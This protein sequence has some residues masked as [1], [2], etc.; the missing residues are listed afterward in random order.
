MFDCHFKRLSSARGSA[1]QLILNTSDYYYCTRVVIVGGKVQKQSVMLRLSPPRWCDVANFLRLVA[2]SAAT[3]RLQTTNH[4]STMS[5]H[6]HTTTTTHSICFYLDL[7]QS[8]VRQPSNGHIKHLTRSRT[9]EEDSRFVLAEWA[10]SAMSELWTVHRE[11]EMSVR[12]SRE[13]SSQWL[14]Q[15][16]CLHKFGFLS[17]LAAWSREMLRSNEQFSSLALLSFS[18]C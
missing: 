18:Q 4:T 11:D 12:Y 17:P 7:P 9:T 1:A 16:D 14:S 10:Q 5:T 8:T 13:N 3:V 6:K 2:S 15:S